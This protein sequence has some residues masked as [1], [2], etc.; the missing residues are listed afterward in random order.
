MDSDGRGISRAGGVVSP[1]P[2][3][4]TTVREELDRAARA[5][6]AA[7]VESA[8]LNAEL[9]MAKV[10]GMA[11][12]RMLIDQRRE[13]ADPEVASFQGWVDRRSR[14]TPLQHI[15]GSAT[16]LDHEI[17]VSSDV[18][19]PR[20]ET[21]GLAQLA[22]EH[23]RRHGVRRVLDFGTGSGCLA[24]AVAAAGRGLEVHALDVSPAAL[25][26]AG[27]NA[28]ANGVGGIVRF[29]PGDGF[30]ALGAWRS[31]CPEAARHGFGLIV[32]NPPYIPTAEIET[33]DP[34]VRDHDPRLALDGGIDGLEFY[35][36]L[37][38]EAGGWLTPDGV[39]MAEFGDGQGPVIQELFAKV[40]GWGASRLE[41]DLSGR[42]R[43]LIVGRGTATAS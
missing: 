42:E 25:A 12:P 15:V 8:R 24:I 37:A 26:L 2:A 14:R 13:L 39:L 11:R 10:L 30:A 19:V 40:G 35:R 21:E 3:M 5:L 18:L 23:V 1:P 38:R 31:E 29:H 22:I 27:R 4:S 7:G 32:S 16:F 20:P 34:E 33:L 36:R 41:K 6:E 28:R 17:E 9:L 43:L